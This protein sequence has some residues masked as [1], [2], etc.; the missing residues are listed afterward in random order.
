[1]EPN[2]EFLEVVRR[3]FSPDTPIVVGC[4]SG[5]RSQTGCEILEKAG[6]TEAV[7]LLG[8][9]GGV[10]DEQG[11]LVQPGWRDEGLPVSTSNEGRDYASLRGA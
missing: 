8:G 4:A 3:H 2:P 5:R 7:N 1:M 9:F 11:R 10:R 6:Y